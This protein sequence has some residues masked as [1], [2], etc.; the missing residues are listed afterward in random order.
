M[1]WACRE[2]AGPGDVVM[3][4]PHFAIFGTRVPAY[5][6][7]SRMD[8]DFREESL[9][10]VQTHGVPQTTYNAFYVQNVRGNT[11][12]EMGKFQLITCAPHTH[13]SCELD[14]QS[15]IQH[16]PASEARW[17]C[18]PAIYHAVSV[19]VFEEPTGPVGAAVRDGAGVGVESVCA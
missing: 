6:S 8:D 9:L 7:F 16:T 3:Q 12:I 2:V 10:G 11:N 13:A 18:T 17:A 5:C 15:N 1:L 14:P 4:T 19:T